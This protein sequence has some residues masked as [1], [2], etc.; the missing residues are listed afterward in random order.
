MVA[1]LRN[2]QLMTSLQSLSMETESVGSDLVTH[3][4][5][6]KTLLSKSFHTHGLQMNDLIFQSIFNFSTPKPIFFHEPIHLDDL[7]TNPSLRIRSGI[8]CLEI[9]INR[10]KSDVNGGVL[11]YFSQDSRQ[12]RIVLRFNGNLFVLNSWASEENSEFCQLPAFTKNEKLYI[13]ISH[14]DKHLE[15]LT[16]GYRGKVY[17]LKNYVTLKPE[18][19]EIFIANR[20]KIQLRTRDC[21][22]MEFL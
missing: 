1:P 2:L 8:H 22:F 14:F 15:R 9:E 13:F 4:T 11:F 3:Y 20:S 21:F 7:R 12:E 18:I 6:L 10:A 5:K 16:L 19:I 17:D